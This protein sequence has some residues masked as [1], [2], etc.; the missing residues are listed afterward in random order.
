MILAQ[1]G[2]RWCWSSTAQVFSMAHHPFCQWRDL[3]WGEVTWNGVTA[4]KP[5]LKVPSL[6]ACAQPASC[7]SSSFPMP[8]PLPKEGRGQQ[9]HT[10]AMLLFLNIFLG[11]QSWEEE[12]WTRKCYDLIL[13]HVSPTRRKKGKTACSLLSLTACSPSVLFLFLLLPHPLLDPLQAW[14]STI[15][16]AQAATKWGARLHCP[17]PIFDLSALPEDLINLFIKQCSFPS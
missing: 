2:F 3:P 17:N 1:C 9:V 4:T 6:G 12:V 5:R 15:Q 8:A 13:F 7:P 14:G 11:I 16:H 10:E